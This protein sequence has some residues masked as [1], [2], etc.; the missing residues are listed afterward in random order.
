MS[1]IL[2]SKF[3]DEW[4]SP[5]LQDVDHLAAM[6]QP[7]PASEMQADR[8]SE[9]GTMRGTTALGMSSSTRAAGC[10][11]WCRQL[12]RGDDTWAAFSDRYQVCTSAISRHPTAIH[13]VSGRAPSDQLCLPLRGDAGLEEFVKAG[14]P[15][16]HRVPLSLGTNG[17]LAIWLI[18]DGH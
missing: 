1:V 13:R 10:C 5:D 15:D 17:F 12:A 11:S 16:L 14:T 2:Q 3:Y 18:V 9:S 4:L 6:L 8:A 7:Y